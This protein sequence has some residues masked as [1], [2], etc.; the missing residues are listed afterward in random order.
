[1]Q[2]VKNQLDL[3]SD[4]NPNPDAMVEDMVEDTR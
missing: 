2:R 4:L 1:M 3:G